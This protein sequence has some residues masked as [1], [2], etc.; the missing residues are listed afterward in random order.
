MP[1]IKTLRASLSFK[2]SLN[3]QFSSTVLFTKLPAL[4]NKY[5]TIYWKNLIR[6]F[7]ELSIAFDFHQNDL[8]TFFNQNVMILSIGIDL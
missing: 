8:T 6:S 3:G 4:I 2:Y 1:L 5:E 7:I